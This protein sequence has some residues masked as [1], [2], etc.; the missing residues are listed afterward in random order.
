MSRKPLSIFMASTGDSL[1]LLTLVR[2]YAMKMPLTITRGWRCHRIN[3]H[4]AYLGN[5]GY[6]H[7]NFHHHFP[8]RKLWLF[9]LSTIRFAQKELHSNIQRCQSYFER[10][11]TANLF[12]KIWG[13]WYLMHRLSH[14]LNRD[15]PL[16]SG[17]D[18]RVLTKIKYSSLFHEYYAR[19]CSL[20][21]T[22]IP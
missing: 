5:T 14:F 2:N 12:V 15:F 6:P 8:F 17:K 7:R 10:S 4:R 3:C 19:I 9:H 22:L 1:Q 16:I 13:R 18:T 20:N 11:K 21:F